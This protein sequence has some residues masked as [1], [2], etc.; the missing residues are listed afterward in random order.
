MAIRGA[1]GYRGLWGEV[2]PF[3]SWLLH[4]K[5]WT[6]SLVLTHL[7]NLPLVSSKSCTLGPCLSRHAKPCGG[8]IWG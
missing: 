4:L 5:G 1:V 2:V 8:T 3:D 6:G 7:L